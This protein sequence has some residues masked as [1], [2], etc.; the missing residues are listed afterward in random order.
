LRF[1]IG[2]APMTK[3]VAKTALRSQQLK[4]SW[5]QCDAEF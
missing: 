3:E 2:V 1:G 5:A 4:L